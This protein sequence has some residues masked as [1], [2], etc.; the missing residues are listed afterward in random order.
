MWYSGMREPLPLLSS[1]AMVYSAGEM[2]FSHMLSRRV[3]YRRYTIH[4]LD[5]YSIV[6]R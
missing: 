1:S 2:R 5:S 6:L 4:Y 3:W